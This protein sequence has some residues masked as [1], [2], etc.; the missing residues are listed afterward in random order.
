ML[1]VIQVEAKGFRYYVLNK[2]SLFR[3]ID[4]HT[5]VD[6]VGNDRR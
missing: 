5:H 2:N 1:L 3:S 4:L 6:L